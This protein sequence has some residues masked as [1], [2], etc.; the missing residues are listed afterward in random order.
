MSESVPST[1]GSLAKIIDASFESSKIFSTLPLFR[2]ITI[3]PL[4]KRNKAILELL[5]TE[6]KYI[7]SLLTM[8]AIYRRPILEASKRNLIQISESLINRIF[9]VHLD[10]IVHVNFMLLQGFVERINNWSEVQTLGDLLLNLVP[11]LKTYVSYMSSYDITVKILEDVENKTILKRFFENRYGPPILDLRSYLIMPVQ[12]IPRY[13][14]MLNELIKHTPEDHQD[15]PD[16]T[17][18]LSEI[19]TV[20]NLIDEAVAF[21]EKRDKLLKIQALLEGEKIQIFEAGR[22]LLEEG[23]LLKVCRKDQ[24]KRYFWLFS[25]ILVYA[26]QVF[27]GRYSR[28][29]KFYL[30]K[31]LTRDIKDDKSVYKNAF[32]IESEKKSFVVLAQ[33]EETKKRWMDAFSMAISKSK[34]SAETIKDKDSMR[35]NLIAPVWIPDHE[36]LTCANCGVKFTIIER[37]HHCRRCGNVVCTSCSNRKMYLPGQGVKRVCNTCHEKPIDK[38]Y[39]IDP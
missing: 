38:R 20:A 16:L 25:D 32:R 37:R 35:S 23:E 21:Q 6:Q 2:E 39:S 4:S 10:N 30:N 31:M 13:R 17:R 3:S 33:N 29:R 7:L 5:Q 27:K 8:D 28:A 18:A 26:K 11:F 15:Y 12:R 34:S 1:E 19:N 9:S 14:L 22:V 24:Q 36:A